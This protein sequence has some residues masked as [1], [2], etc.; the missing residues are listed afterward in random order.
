MQFARVLILI[1]VFLESAGAQTAQRG[2]TS[3][4]APQRGGAPAPARGGAASSGRVYANLGQLMKGILYPNSNVIF[5]AQNQNPAEVKPAQDPATAT[6]PLASTYG[7]W[8]AVE[9]SALAL[10]EAASLLLVPGRRCANGRPVPLQ[11]PDWPKFVQGLREAGMTVYK[12]AQSKDQDKI[13]DAAD[14]MTTACA[15]CHDKYREKTN[16]ADRCQ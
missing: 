10:S 11:N 2:G 9:N 12:A 5:A 16:L 6:D 7:K 15:N 8:E 4:P 3:A 13:I 14:V 1:L